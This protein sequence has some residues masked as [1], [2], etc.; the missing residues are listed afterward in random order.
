M[1]SFQSDNRP[2]IAAD[3]RRRVLV[4]A[5]HRCAIP[6]CRHIEVDIHHIIPWAQCQAHEYDNLIAI[7]PNCHRR[8]DRGEID[9]KSL[10]LYKFNLRFA[11]DKYSQLE[12]DILFELYK[13]AENTALPWFSYMMI[14]L[15]RIADSGFIK[16]HEVPAGMAIGLAGGTLKTTPDL[17]M[18]TPQ[19]RSFIED[20]GLHEL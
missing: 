13:L 10:R 5:G 19:G 12:M 16:M 14:L 20:L 11:H 9:R 8:A 4:E 6:S 2:R 3:I 7:C 18:I 1:S 17:I 15:K